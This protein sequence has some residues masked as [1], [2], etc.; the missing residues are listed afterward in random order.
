MV[1]NFFGTRNGFR[2]RQFF[3]GRWGGVRRQLGKVK[4]APEMLWEDWEWTEGGAVPESDLQAGTGLIS[5]AA[6]P[7]PRL[8]S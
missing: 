8:L 2:K 6:P 7:R 3:R 1:P 4:V 5:H